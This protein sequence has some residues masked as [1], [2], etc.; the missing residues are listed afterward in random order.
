MTT[1]S[2]GEILLAWVEAEPTVVLGVLIGSRARPGGSAGAADDFSDWDFQIATTAPER[3]ATGEWLAAIGLPP[4]AYVLRP[5]RLGSAQKVSAVT[6][7]GEVDLVIISAEA[8]RALVQVVAAGA[9]GAHPPAGQA[10]A[11]L[12]AVLAGGYRIVKGAG[13][14]APFFSRVAREMPPPPLDDGTVLRLAEGFVCDYVFTRRK[15]DR[16]ELLAARRWLHHQLMESN[17]RLLH[18]LRRR[19]GVA[20][21][22]DGRRLEELK[23]NR[24]GEFSAGADASAEG[25]RAAVEDAAARHRGLMAALVGAQWRWPDLSGLGLRAE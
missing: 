6:P 14:F 15:I 1:K 13:E 8:L 5:G 11:D 23:E 19:E 16:G 18:E 20:S 24:A 25:L 21:F 4:L 17:F 3:F 10:L 2:L 9:Q 22:P 12:G 7:K